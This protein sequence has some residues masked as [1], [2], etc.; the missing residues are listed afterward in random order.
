MRKESPMSRIFFVMPFILFLYNC[1]SQDEYN[2]GTS[3]SYTKAPFESTFES[4]FEFMDSF[5]PADPN[6]FTLS[7]GVNLKDFDHVSH[8]PNLLTTKTGLGIEFGSTQE[9]DYQKWKKHKQVHWV[10]INI[11]TNEILDKSKNA[12]ENLY[13]ASISKAIVA[14][15]ALDKQGGMFKS[16]SQWQDMFLLLVESKNNPYWDRVQNLAGGISGVNEFTKKMG[17]TTM[18]AAHVASTDGH[19]ADNK[20]SALELSMFYH[21]LF[22]EGFAG[23]EPLFK[24]MSACNTGRESPTRK[25]PKYIPKAIYLGGKTGTVSPSDHDSRFFVVNGVRYAIIVLSEVSESTDRAE[26]VAT[27]FGG[28]FREYVLGAN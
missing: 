7:N 27:T 15:A 2:Y 10:V 4:T 14:A 12:S 21:D 28:L 11:D 3:L 18:R 5:D 22:H 17:Y 20:V 25:G 1:G 26:L 19:G 6:F 9:K 24:V 16:A 8:Y 23:T 13:G